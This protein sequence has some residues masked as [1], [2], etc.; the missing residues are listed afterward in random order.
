[1]II[2]AYAGAGKSTFAARFENAVDVV[3]MPRSCI[4]PPKNRKR[5][6]NRRRAE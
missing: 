6:V 2:A 5:N 1:M 4:L 3:S